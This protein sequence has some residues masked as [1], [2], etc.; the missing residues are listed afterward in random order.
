MN[1]REKGNAESVSWPESFGGTDM[2]PDE[3]SSI[4]V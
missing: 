4:A 1:S 3:G 2:M